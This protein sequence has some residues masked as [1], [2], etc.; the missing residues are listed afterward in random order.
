LSK[1][2]GETAGPA[3]SFEP[4]ASRV[5]RWSAYAR[6]TAHRITKSRLALPG[7]RAAIDS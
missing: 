2:Q 7:E 1:R 5:F 6:A 4:S 3:L